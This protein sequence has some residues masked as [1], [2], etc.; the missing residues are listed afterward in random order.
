[1]R[2]LSICLAL[3]MMANGHAA[4]IGQKGWLRLMPPGAGMTA[5][6]VELFNPSQHPIVV[7]E[8]KCPE[9]GQCMIHETVRDQKGTMTMRHVSELTIPAEGSVRLVPGAKHLMV[10]GLTKPLS[11]GTEVIIEFCDAEQQ[12]WPV[13][14]RVSTEQPN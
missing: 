10:M 13:R 7:T 9:L 14:F 6:Y 8:V 1:M 12:C 11:D 5:G 4:I 3:I 2:Y